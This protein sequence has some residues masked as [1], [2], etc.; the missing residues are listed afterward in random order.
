[1]QGVW[2]LISCDDPV[3]AYGIRESH[4]RQAD[5]RRAK[6]RVR[7]EKRQC[8]KEYK[9]HRVTKSRPR[10]ARVFIE[11][12][13]DDKGFFRAIA[14]VDGEKAISRA[15]PLPESPAAPLAGASQR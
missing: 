8:E 9:S 3:V 12:L 7:K 13:S 10:S 6:N 11:K 4:A 15:R 1:M 5:E 14:T 2:R